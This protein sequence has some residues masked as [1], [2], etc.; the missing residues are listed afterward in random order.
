MLS[1]FRVQPK[2]LIE[3]AKKGI[4]ATNPAVRTAAIT[5]VGTL[6]LYMGPPLRTFFEGEKPALVQQLNTEFDKVWY[7]AVIWTFVYFK[8][9]FKPA[10]IPFQNLC[11]ILVYLLY[12]N[13]L[14]MIVATNSIPVRHL[15]SL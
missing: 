8:F 2:P 10:C 14:C 12:Y 5:L 15:Q 11:F 9:R 1:F 7:E 4:S 13:R 3:T 6:F